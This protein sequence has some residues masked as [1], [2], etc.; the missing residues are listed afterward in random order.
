MKTWKLLAGAALVV[1][2]SGCGTSWTDYKSDSGK[3]TAQFPGTP[4]EKEMSA[5]GISA[6]GVVLDRG[7]R[8]FTVMYADLPG[9][10]DQFK[11]AA[12]VEMSLDGAATGCVQNVKGK[13]TALDKIKLG[14][15]PGRDV[16]AELPD[17]NELRNR[18]YMVNGRLYQVMVLGKKGYTTSPDAEKF[19]TSF[20]LTQ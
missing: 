19:L 20:K 1:V 16:K 14:D 3:F 13:Q 8:A 15:H 7:D 10:A 17:G 2:M 9:S 5:A 6:K 18:I 11:N 4:Q 12:L